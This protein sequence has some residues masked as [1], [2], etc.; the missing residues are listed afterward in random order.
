MTDS[1]REPGVG[2]TTEGQVDRDSGVL[3]HPKFRM[4][5]RP[6]DIVQMAWLPSVQIDLEDAIAASE[7]MMELTGGRRSPLLVDLHENGMPTRPARRELA[8]RDDLVSAV[9]LIV[10]TPLSRT[11]GNF[12]LGV[13]KPQYPTRLFDDE[14]PALAWL[15]AFV[16]S[17]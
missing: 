11:I 15:Q 4:W 12:F 1:L 16:P 3:S 9:A 17:R 10:G 7:A 8:R 5:L 13:N 6:D 14:P 2:A